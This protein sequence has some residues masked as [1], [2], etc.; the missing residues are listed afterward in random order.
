MQDNLFLS[1]T[2][3]KIVIGLVDSGAFNGAY[4][5]NP[6]HFQH[7]N[8]NYLCLYM[9]GRAIPAKA[10]TPHFENGRYARAY[11][12][13][14]T[15]LGT[16]NKNA[17]NGIQYGDYPQGYTLYGFD[18]SPSL[19]DGDQFELVKSGALCLEMHFA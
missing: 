2:P 14:L 1:Q 17:G 9:D 4:D 12:S 19:L 5:K 3:A 16:V 18:L 13:L 10:L 6:F 11:H 15:A 7:F 8:L